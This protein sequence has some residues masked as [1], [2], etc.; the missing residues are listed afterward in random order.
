MKKS[1]G[2]IGVIF[3]CLFLMAVTTEVKAEN[4][5]GEKA[6]TGFANAALGWTEIG[7][8]PARGVTSDRNL[9]EKIFGFIPDILR[10]TGKAIIREGS[11]FLDLGLSLFPGNNIV[12]TR[13]IVD[14]HL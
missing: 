11:G 13:P 2:V 5:V 6:L 9:V 14:D 4:D 10:G 3:A 1:V 8:E 12:G 7:A